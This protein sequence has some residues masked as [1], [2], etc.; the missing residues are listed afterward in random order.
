MC[1]CETDRLCA[2][3]PNVCS[4]LRSASVRG[5]GSGVGDRETAGQRRYIAVGQRFAAPTIHPSVPMQASGVSARLSSPQGSL[6]RRLSG[7]RRSVSVPTRGRSVS[8]IL[9]RI[10]ARQGS[11]VRRDRSAAIGQGSEV[12]VSGDHSPRQG[13][14]RS[15]AR[16]GSAAIGQGSAA[17]RRGRSGVG[18]RPT[19]GQRSARQGS[20]VG[21]LGVGQGSASVRSA[22][23]YGSRS[24]GGEWSA[25][26]GRR[27]V[28]DR[29]AIGRENET[30][31]T[32][33]HRVGSRRG[34]RSVL[35]GSAARHYP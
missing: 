31:P 11:A 15:A 34:R 6:I 14:A 8:P 4:N 17:N 28:A 16:Q 24:V 2:C 13:S 33:M 10:S 21:R 22:A 32:R 1:A 35:V 19:R 9:R 3:E 26:I 12:R 20:G 25:P 5:Q 29:S 23:V 18:D 27:S 7:Q 30:D